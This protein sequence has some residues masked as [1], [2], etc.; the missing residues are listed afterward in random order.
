MAPIVAKTMSI[1]VE[2]AQEL[3]RQIAWD[4]AIDMSCNKL[5]FAEER[6]V[7]WTTY[8]NLEL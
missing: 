7:W 5:N 2:S 1:D 6:R 4:M 8:N 3:L